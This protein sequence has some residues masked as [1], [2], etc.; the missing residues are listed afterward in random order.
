[1][2]LAC[3]CKNFDFADRSAQHEGL[4]AFGGAK[5]DVARAQRQP[6]RLADDGAHYNFGRQTQIGDHA[7]HDSTLGCI[8][9]AEEGAVGLGRHEQLGNDG[10]YSAK[11]AGA[12]LAIEAIDEACNLDK[13]GRAG[14]VELFDR[15]GKD[16]DRAFGLSQSAV[17]F[18]AAWIA[19][20][21]FVGSELGGVDED[22]DGDTSAEAFAA[23]ISEA[24]PA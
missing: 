14:R 17:G 23:R 22:A 6:V 4:G 8:L 20:V 1:M 24:W 21:V 3:G 13:R 18:E 7:A 15:W 19:S 5:V 2:A 11:V 12:G 9:L 16:D 10:G